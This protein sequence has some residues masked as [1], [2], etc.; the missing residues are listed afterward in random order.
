M[1]SKIFMEGEYK[2]AGSLLGKI[3][4]SSA[5]AHVVF[6]RTQSSFRTPPIAV[7]YYEHSQKIWTSAENLYPC[8]RFLVPIC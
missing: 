7:V 5:I 6:H 3:A 2:R 8:R 1:A 4:K